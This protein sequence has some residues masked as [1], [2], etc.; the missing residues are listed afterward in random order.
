LSWIIAGLITGIVLWSLM[1]LWNIYNYSGYYS[2]HSTSAMPLERTPRVSILVPARNEAAMLPSTLPGLLRQDY[3][4]YEVVLVDD[5]SSDGTGDVAERIARELPPE[6][7]RRLRLIRSQEALPPGWVGKNH[8]LHLAFESVG[9]QPA[10]SE[11]VLATDA[12]IVY[13]PKAL[14]A[15]L[16]IAERQKADLVTIFAFLNC[17][18]FWEKLFMPGFAV[19]LSAVFP[20]R[21]INSPRSSVALASGG[22]ILMRRDVWA[23]QGG[24]RAI[25]SD[26]IDDL[27]TARIVKHSGHRIFAAATCDLIS[28]RMYESFREVWEGLRKNAFAGHRFNVAKALAATGGYLLC[29][30]LPLAVLLWF[31]VRWL[32]GGGKAVGP[33]ATVVTLA[34]AE[35]FLVGLLHLPMLLFLNIGAGFGLLSPIAATLYAIITLDSVART[36]AGGGVSWKA[37]QYGKPQRPGGQ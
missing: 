8:A 14:R 1:L 13:H 35:Y 11:W 34:A 15:G 26:M 2:M 31:G 24:Y 4:D 33:E 16:S 27:N 17:E 22:Y 10:P 36:L 9:A 21:L 5:G 23:A 29:N 28:T 32:A 3:P 12:D 6:D 25:A 18:S 37:R 19:L 7:G 20:Q 30:A